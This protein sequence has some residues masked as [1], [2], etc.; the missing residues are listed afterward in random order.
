LLRRASIAAEVGIVRDYFAKEGVWE[1]AMRQQFDSLTR[2]LVLREECADR[3]LAAL[4]EVD[5]RYRANF[6]RYTPGRLPLLRDEL[7]ATIRSAGWLLAT[8]PKLLECKDDHLRSIAEV[9]PDLLK[10]LADKGIKSAYS[11]VTKFLHFC[12]PT[13]FAIHDSQAAKSIAMWAIFAF[14]EDVP[15]DASLASR[16]TESKLG[17]P[18][19]YGYVHVLRFYRQIWD[20]GT[21]Q[22]KEA[23][24]VQAHQLEGDLRNKTWQSV[25]HVTAVDLIDKLVWKA[26]GN[27]IRLRLAAPP[28]DKPTTV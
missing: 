11:L 8:P 6:D 17:D 19:G 24:A 26:A 18:G 1:A 4:R 5:L 13:T 16:F 12:F 22:D 15:G 9:V 20:A 27:P 28:S 3:A 2:S 25:A 7:V 23:L 10:R 21:A 14:D